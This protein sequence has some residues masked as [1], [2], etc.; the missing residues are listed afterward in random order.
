M[1]DSENREGHEGEDSRTIAR[2]CT[3]TDKKPMKRQPGQAKE[4][5][6]LG[7]NQEN[8][9]RRLKTEDNTSKDRSEPKQV[10]ACTWY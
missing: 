8:V 7:N 10:R 3:G 9:E 4:D 2:G 1:A 6:S 5:R